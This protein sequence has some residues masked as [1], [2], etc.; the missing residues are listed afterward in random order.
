MSIKIQ[1]L[2][3]VLV[4]DSLVILVSHNQQCDY[5]LPSA[6]QVLIAPNLKEKGV[7]STDDNLLVFSSQNVTF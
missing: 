3:T 5:Q 2:L 7:S 1:G 4:D 6:H